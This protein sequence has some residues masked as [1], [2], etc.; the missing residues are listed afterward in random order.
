MKISIVLAA[1]NGAKYITE[2]L[3]SLRTQS[4]S[5]DEVIIRDDCSTDDTYDIC[6]A[7]IER[8]D[9]D[10]SL[11][12]ADKNC[13]YRENFRA[14]IE[15]SSGDWVLL[16]DQDDIWEREKIDK[17]ESTASAHA[18]AAAVACSFSCIDGKGGCIPLPPTPGKGNHGLI[19]FELPNGTAPLEVAQKHPELLLVQNIAMGCC[20]G[21]RKDVCD[22]YLRLTEC[23]F[24]HDWELALI[25]SYAGEIY[26]I[27][28]PLIQYR[29]HGNNAI[30]LPGMFPKDG[31][32]VP[33]ETGRIKVMDEFDG[34]LA[35]A[36][37]I[38]ADMGKQPLSPRYAEYSRLRREAL[39]Q[40]SLVKWLL[41]HRYGDIY[42]RM[43]TLKQRLGDLYIIVKRH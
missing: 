26:F 9:L 6:A 3:D 31:P 35:S 28:E 34:L 20:M 4:R 13:G 1:Y 15:I 36:Q 10:W 23:G 38:L 43:F 41:L 33:S 25:A 22:R 30:G 7:F 32:K 14:A 2:Q 21:F 5:A 24:P 11:I 27:N 19:P 42:S 37:R 17:F 18:D 8:Y 16:C 40:R 39:M 12:K 29:L